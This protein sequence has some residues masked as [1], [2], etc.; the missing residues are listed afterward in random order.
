MPTNGTRKPLSEDL[1]TECTPSLLQR[2][3]WLM[4]LDSVVLIQ[5]EILAH[6]LQQVSVIR[7]PVRATVRITGGI[8][9]DCKR[10]VAT[11]NEEFHLFIFEF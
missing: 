11:R 4:A 10:V 2:S 5:P 8:I 6:Y 7:S 9:A 3:L 1:R